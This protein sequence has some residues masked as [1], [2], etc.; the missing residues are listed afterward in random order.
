MEQNGGSHFPLKCCDMVSKSIGNS[1]LLFSVVIGIWS[2]DVDKMNR[3]I[4][5]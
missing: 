1:Y 4:I 5:M 2:I 3:E